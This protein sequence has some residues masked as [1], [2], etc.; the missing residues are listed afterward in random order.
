MI[1]EVDRAWLS[2]VLD[3]LLASWQHHADTSNGLF[4]PYLDRRWHRRPD[5]PRTLVSQCRLSYNFVRA[6][7][8]SGDQAY[9]ALAHRGLH[10]L[11]AYFRAADGQGWY[12]AC[13]GDGTVADET[14]DAYGHAFVILAFATAAAVLHDPHYRDLALQTWQF[15]QQRFHDPYGGLVW[16][17]DRDGR[18]LDEL[19]SQNP[20]MHC[21]EALVTLAPLDDSGIIRRDAAAIWQFL[22]PRM[23][24]AGCLPEWYTPDWQ[25]VRAGAQA[26]IEVG[27][28]FEWAYLLSEA[29]A[30]GLDEA[31]LPEGRALLAYGMQHGYDAAEGGTFSQVGLDGTRRAERKGWWEQCEAIRALHRYASRHGADEVVEPQQRSLAFVRRHYVDETYGGWYEN[32]PGMGG[33]V[34][35]EKGTAWKLDYHVVNMCRELLADR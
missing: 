8:R 4:Y 18:I 31:L 22:R 34:S 12:W 17:V 35:L 6:F 19:R 32:P 14:A 33:V 1:D 11:L 20:L 21:F 9:A 23:L 10:A 16:H 29:Q 15:V 27:H 7:E 5:G 30:V 26:V 24:S 13:Q 25:P 3:R 28:A 2:S